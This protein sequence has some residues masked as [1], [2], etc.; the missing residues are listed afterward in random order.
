MESESAGHQVLRV[1]IDWGTSKVAVA[2]QIAIP[3][4]QLS[5][6]AI[7]DVV[8]DGNST[9]APQQIALDG[10][11]IV[12]GHELRTRLNRGEILHDKV[13]SLLKIAFYQNHA[14]SALTERVMEQVESLKESL[15]EK[16]PDR[17]IYDAKVLLLAKHLKSVVEFTVRQLESKVA[18]KA[19]YPEGMIGKMPV[20]LYISVPGMWL[21]PG[22]RNML[23]AANL[24]GFSRVEIVNEPQASLA[25]WA[26]TLVP[27]EVGMFNTGDE[28]FILDGGGGTSDVAL[29]EL[30]TDGNT[31]S[32]VQLKA[33]GEA[34]GELCGSEFIN[35]EFLSWFDTYLERNGHN[36]SDLSRKLGCPVSE[37][38]Y[39]A[40]EDFNEIKET[41][42]RHSKKGRIVRIVGDESSELKEFTVH[43]SSEQI[44]EFFEPV[45]RMNFDLVRKRLV[46]A[47]AVK[48]LIVAG[49]LSHSKYF[50]TQLREEFKDSGM[51][52]DSAGVRAVGGCNP[53]TRGT[54]LKCHEFST[55]DLPITDCFGISEDQVYNQSN[56]SDL[57][58][59]LG[60]FGSAALAKTQR[61][62]GHSSQYYDDAYAKDRWHT[63]A[64]ANPRTLQKFWQLRCFKLQAAK[65]FL[66]QVYWSPHKIRENSPIFTTNGGS[67]LQDGIEKFGTPIRVQL[68]D[69]ANARFPLKQKQTEL[70]KKQ[71]KLISGYCIRC[72]KDHIP[73]SLAYEEI[74]RSCKNK[75]FYEVYYRL[76]LVFDG[77]NIRVMVKIAKPE[78]HDAICKG[79]EVGPDGIFSWEE[80]H[81][82]I[83]ESQNPNTRV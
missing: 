6:H 53:V 55:R 41:F 80:E 75:Q 35:Q 52:I 31:G 2:A 50:M 66:I 76:E 83:S 24:A 7:H 56:H 4:Q 33:V 65:V 59:V 61:P 44:A 26:H 3:G 74:C 43:L 5:E 30:Q 54:L 10:D 82:F 79:E 77:A 14:T 64:P 9:T 1:A 70:S 25:H 34:S 38:T 68:P 72:H 27:T 58:H 37:F 28:L 20:E 16:H 17:K 19:Q 71:R 49:G 12:W 36:K 69:L 18:T 81:L 13:I 48:V 47:R 67:Q 63:I 73:A 8:F 39:Q 23:E 45:L 42:D 15:I 51:L 40:N 78:S 21:P 60:E 11:D 32:Q 46:S 57:D 22:N 29:Y 62:Q